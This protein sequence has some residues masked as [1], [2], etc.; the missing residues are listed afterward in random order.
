MKAMIGIG[1]DNI[2]RVE[3]FWDEVE[4]S[5][6]VAFFDVYDG[7][8]Q[9][10]LEEMGKQVWGSKKGEELELLRYETKM[11]MKNKLD[12]AVQPIKKIK[13]LPKL[14][15]YLKTVE[16]KYIKI[17][18]FRGNCE[19]FHHINYELT[20][21]DLDDMELDMGATKHLV[22]FIVEDPLP[23]KEEI[24]YDGFCIDGKYPNTSICGIE[25]KDK[26]YAGEFREYKDFPIEITSVNE[27]LSNIFKKYRY[28]CAFSSEIR[29]GK[30]KIPYMLDFTNRCPEPPTSLAMEMYE[31]YAEIIWYG[32]Q[33]ICINPIATGKFGVEVIMRCE[34]AVKRWTKVS[35]KDKKCRPYIKFKSLM[36]VNDEMW[37]PPMGYC[38]IGA[39]IGIGNTLEQAIERCKEYAEEVVCPHIEINVHNL[40]CAAEEIAKTEKLGIKI[41]GK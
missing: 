10:H 22:E 20:E 17:D 21:P 25:V 24:G 7:D 31:N 12:M 2:E 36:V 30:D 41:F 15:E 9:V 5:D 28:R 14:R 4:K 1:V 11:Y 33:G 8:M 40:N 6:V 3:N 18:K 13:G 19:T 34:N 37:I 32:S 27:K 23:D 39:V 29:V 35:I 26:A 38:E 16:D